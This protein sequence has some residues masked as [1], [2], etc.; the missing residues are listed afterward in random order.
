MVLWEAITELKSFTGS[1]RHTSYLRVVETRNNVNDRVL[2][3][4]F[5]SFYKP[6]NV[7]FVYDSIKKVFL[8]GS[9]NF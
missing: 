3:V 9:M 6:P 4:I 1:W 2:R 5:I 7:W 8:P